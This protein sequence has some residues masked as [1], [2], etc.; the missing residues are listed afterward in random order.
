MKDL[1]RRESTTATVRS[2]RNPKPAPPGLPK[3][4]G[5]RPACPTGIL[6]VKANYMN[7]RQ[8]IQS[9][10]A[11][12]TLA[13][14]GEQSATAAPPKRAL[15]KLGCQSAPTNETHL[16]YFARYGVRDIC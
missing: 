4:H 5:S 16:K 2:A 13:G 1:C 14:L 12:T 8:F 11:A 10:G 9:S 3:H 7:R 6:P 15:M